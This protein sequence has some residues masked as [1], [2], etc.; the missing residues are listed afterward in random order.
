MEDD[1]LECDDCNQKF[2]IYD[3]KIFSDDEREECSP[4]VNLKCLCNDCYELS[5]KNR[6]NEQRKKSY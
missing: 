4:L 2:I 3:M 6:I 5:R 1:L